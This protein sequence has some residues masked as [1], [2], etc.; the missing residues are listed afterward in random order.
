MP[1][2]SHGTEETMLRSISHTQC[3]LD[4]TTKMLCPWRPSYNPHP[5]NTFRS[6]R[7]EA[8]DSNAKSS[9]P[10]PHPPS[11]GRLPPF[12]RRFVKC[13][14]RERLNNAKDER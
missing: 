1:L 3:V 7:G 9:H 6:L 8:K 4:F 11:T 2:R 5:G 12:G 13:R 14:R 10:L